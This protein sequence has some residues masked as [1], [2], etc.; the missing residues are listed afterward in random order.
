[1]GEVHGARRFCYGEMTVLNK[2]QRWLKAAFIY[3]W[4]LGEDAGMSDYEW[5]M[6]S[7]KFY[8]ERDKMTLPEHAPLHREEFTGGS[9]FWLPKDEYPAFVRAND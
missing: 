3:Y 9:L 2:Y 5:D 7:R 1:M 4:G 6:L 8:A